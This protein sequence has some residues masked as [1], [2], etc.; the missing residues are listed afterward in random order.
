MAETPTRASWQKRTLRIVGGLV[1][2]I[3]LFVLALR[4]TVSEMFRGIAQSRATG[5]AALSPW[6]SAPML[7]KSVDF[8]F[9]PG[10]QV[11]RS[12]DLSMRS[13][14]FERSFATLQQVVAAHHGYLEDLRTESRSGDGRALAATVTVPANEFDATLSGLKTLGRIEALSESGEDAAVKLAT[15]ARHLD[16]AQTNLSRLQ[17]LRREQKGQLRDALEVEKEIAQADSAVREAARQ[18]DALLSTV[19][20]AHIQITLLE[21]FR[22][23]FE[24]HLAEASL[25]LRN[26]FVEGV[27]GIFQS[28]AL[29]VGVGFEYGLPLLFW[30]AILLWP[31]RALWRR[32]RPRRPAMA[33]AEAQS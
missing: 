33:P 5:L 19:A 6:E 20:Q 30:G 26:S 13:S 11:S 24:A 15:A 3:L 22:A 28:V 17:R 18:Q 7:R 27:G 10:S 16:A 21:D 25:R 23:P 2:F 29:V 12:A 9:T 14:A 32:F 8:A 31:A 1:T 4:I